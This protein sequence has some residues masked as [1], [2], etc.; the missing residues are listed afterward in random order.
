MSN[1]IALAISDTAEEVSVRDKLNDI[2][3]LL[4]NLNVQVTKYVQTDNTERKKGTERV[5]DCTDWLRRGHVTSGIY[6]VFPETLWRPIKVYC[7]METSG[8]GWTVFQRRQDGSEN[9]NRKWID[10]AF[11]FGNLSGE[12]W[13]GNEFI[14]RLTSVAPQELLIELEDFENDHRHAAYGLFSVG[15]A[16]EAFKLS[17]NFFTG[18]VTDTLV[19]HHNGLGFSTSDHGSSTDCSNSYKGGW[20]YGKCHSVNINGLYLKGNHTSYANGVNW[21]AWH[22]YHYSLKKTEMKFRPH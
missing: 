12:F 11:G 20:W 21:K 6:T 16:E 17:V 8:G 4:E 14:H 10:Y 19:S 18:N 7:D 1:N 3:E 13:L 5:P 15:S 9:F 2:V 22:G